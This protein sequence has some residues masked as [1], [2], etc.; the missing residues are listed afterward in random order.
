MLSNYLSFISRVIAFVF[1][2]EAGG[3]NGYFADMLEH[4]NTTHNIKK[5][6]ELAIQYTV[7]YSL[8]TFMIM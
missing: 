5:K 3:T 6:R 7:E 2:S 4:K 1:S 8:F